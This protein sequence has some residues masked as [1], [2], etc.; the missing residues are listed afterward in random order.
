MS[1]MAMSERVSTMA[2]NKVLHD[3][4]GAGAVQGADQRQREDVVP[5]PD[6]RR[7]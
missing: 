4:L 3:H 2:S 7:G 5:Q 1:I 6:D